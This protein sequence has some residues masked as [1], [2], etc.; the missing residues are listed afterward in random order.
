V[1]KECYRERKKET[2]MRFKKKIRENVKGEKVTER[3]D[4]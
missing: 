2:L 3:V 1:E 4:R